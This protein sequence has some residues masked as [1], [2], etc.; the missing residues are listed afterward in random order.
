MCV[1]VCACVCV[2]VCEEKCSIY[3]LTSASYCE[4]LSIVVGGALI[5][6]TPKENLNNA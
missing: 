2:C 3:E 4:F 5:S 1:C 6:G